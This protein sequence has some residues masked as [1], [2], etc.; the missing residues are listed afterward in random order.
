MTDS[1]ISVPRVAPFP[2]YRYWLIGCYRKGLPDYMTSLVAPYVWEDPIVSR[3]LGDS[4]PGF[5]SLTVAGFLSMARGGFWVSALGR[6][7]PL[8][9]VRRFRRGYLSRA[10][11]VDEVW[12]ARA[13]P[14]ADNDFASRLADRYQ[15]DVHV[16]GLR[17]AFIGC[18][19]R[20]PGSCSL[21]WG[22]FERWERIDGTRSCGNLR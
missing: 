6:V 9:R 15:C 7:T 12:I 10:M 17:G 16:S 3:G 14:C 21:L 1:A 20:A 5:H 22:N 19:R 2:A 8:G 4:G 13:L 18:V 11:R